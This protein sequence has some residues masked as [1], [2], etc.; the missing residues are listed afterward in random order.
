M[1]FGVNCYGIKPANKG[2]TFPAPLPGTN[3]KAFDDA[4]NKFKK[5]LGS[6]SLSPFNRSTWSEAGEL[7]LEGHQVLSKVQSSIGTLEKEIGSV[8]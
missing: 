2:T 3:P 1:K 6:I 7:K 8:L 5:M 4:V